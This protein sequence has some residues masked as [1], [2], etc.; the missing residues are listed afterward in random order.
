[1]KERKLGR[2]RGRDQR[3]MHGSRKEP[4]AKEE[5]QAMVWAVAPAVRAYQLIS[6]VDIHLSCAVGHA[7]LP[8]TLELLEREIAF[9]Q[10]FALL[11]TQLRKCLFHSGREFLWRE[12]QQ[13]RRQQRG[14]KRRRNKRNQF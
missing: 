10:L 14:E 9:L 4:S 8:L 13:V 3:A 1:M 12:R 5:A 2:G 11:A 7:L 6:T